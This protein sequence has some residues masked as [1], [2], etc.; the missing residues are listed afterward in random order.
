MLISFIFPSFP[1]GSCLHKPNIWSL[2][3]ILV[4][5]IVVRQNI[6]ITYLIPFTY[7]NPTFLG[8]IQKEKQRAHVRIRTHFYYV[9][10]RK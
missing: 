7:L 5:F 10:I 6:C 8:L 2:D 9:H 3:N 4:V 1:L